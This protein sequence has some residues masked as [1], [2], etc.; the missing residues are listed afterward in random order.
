[1]LAAGGPEDI[2]RLAKA[3]R[4]PEAL[5]YAF[6]RVDTGAS[7]GAIAALVADEEAGV[8]RFAMAAI[9]KAT[10][11]EAD[12]LLSLARALEAPDTAK[13]RV[14]LVAND[15]EPVWAALPDFGDAVE[16]SYWSEFSGFGR[17]ADFELVNEAAR[18]LADHGR[19][20]DALDLLAVYSYGGRNRADPQLV[21]ELLRRLLSVPDP[22]MAVLSQYD[23][24]QLFELLRTAAAVDED[25]VATLEWSFL[26]A[27]EPTQDLL[28]LQRRLADHPQFFVEVIRI[29]FRSKAGDDE[30]SPSSTLTEGLAANGF[31][32]LH[33][34]KVVPGTDIETGEVDPQRLTS[35]V[36]EAR[37]LLADED[38]ADVGD[39]QI[40]QVLA[41]APSGKDGTWPCEPV[42]DL[43]EELAAEH[44][45]S[46][47]EVGIYNKRGVV[48][49]GLDQGGEQEYELERRYLDWAQALAI[50]WPIVAGLLRDVAKTYHAEGVGN[51]E[52][53]QR[54]REGFD[55]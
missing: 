54:F 49:R 33:N 27:L 44:V 23:L 53:A 20:A 37:R 45:N 16:D 7:I 5:G 4:D 2:Y 36:T 21:A 1:V 31:R 46:G 41:Y 10:H 19:V 30:A 39:S 55:R 50:E 17:G 22:E 52:E 43:L 18:G 13:A 3:V 11:Q 9:A 29:V 38:R 6:V 32:L 12:R 42:R 28:T 48:S 25:T 26:P 35:W 51:D 40:G 34:W 15:L 47:F 8:R 14:L 24:E